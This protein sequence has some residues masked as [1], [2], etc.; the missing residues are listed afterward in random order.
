M[1]K[2]NSRREVQSVKKA[3]QVLECV[4]FHPGG[5]S[6]ADISREVAL[7]RN[8]VFQLLNTLCSSGYLLQDQTSRDY[9]PS[10]RLRWLCFSNDIYTRLRHLAQ[11]VLADLVQKTRETAHLAVL[12]DGPY[13]RF[14]EKVEAPQPLVVLTD[15]EVPLPLQI[16]SV[17][18]AILANLSPARQRAL[19]EQIQFTSYTKNTTSS[20][21][22]LQRDLNFVRSF[23]YAKDDEEHFEAVRCVAAAV[24]DK[25]GS[26]VC[27]LGISAPKIRMPD[28]ERA[29]VPVIQAAQ[30]LQQILFP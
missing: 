5:I 22:D 7:N 16:T 2:A 27:A 10:M 9:F 26:P 24:L 12:D 14:L 15:L 17:G 25:D 20:M 29:A 1:E 23:G 3:L 6:L 28:F 8:T 4:I 30:Q 11:P 13:V 18:K 19:L 21:S